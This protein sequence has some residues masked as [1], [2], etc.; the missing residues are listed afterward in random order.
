MLR[1]RGHQLP[2]DASAQLACRSML[3]HP[4]TALLVI[5]PFNLLHMTCLHP[6]Q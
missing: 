5:Y 4:H 2:Y 6:I 3:A 1:R